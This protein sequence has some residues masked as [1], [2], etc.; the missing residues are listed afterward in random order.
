MPLIYI[1]E[2][3]FKQNNVTILE[4]IYSRIELVKNKIQI[5]GTAHQPCG[6]FRSS[7]FVSHFSLLKDAKKRYV[8]FFS[9]WSQNPSSSKTLGLK[10]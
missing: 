8:V 7:V 10:V 6:N 4:L 2:I 1:H 3:H 5:S 9:D